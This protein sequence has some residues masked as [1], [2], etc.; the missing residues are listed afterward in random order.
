VTARKPRVTPVEPVD[1]PGDPES[2]AT[3]AGR[4]RLFT[5]DGVDYTIPRKPPANQVIKYLWQTKQ[6]GHDHAIIQLLEDLAGRPA[7]LAL[8][9]HEDLT[10]EELSDVLATV[11]KATLGAVE[12]GL[13]N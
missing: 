8:M 9:G 1:Q 5:V 13:G 7:V 6:F 10:Y 11:R 4:M 3:P 2:E 12:V